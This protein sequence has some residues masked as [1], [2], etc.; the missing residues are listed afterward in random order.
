M[1]KAK[2][3][4]TIAFFLWVVTF[5]GW[6]ARA[7]T[8]D[9]R[10]GSEDLLAVSVFDHPELSVS[11]RVSK[12]G[13]IT[14]PLLGVLQVSGLTTRELEE[15]LSRRL[16]DGAYVQKAQVSVLVTDYESQK[17]AVMGQVAKPGQYAL[18][19]SNKVLDLL[20][21]AGGV[22]NGSGGGLAY[23]LAGDE[24][25]LVKKDGTKIKINL[26]ALFEGDPSQNPAVT[27]G[28]TIFV[29][30]APVF[31]IYGEV[32]KPGSYKLERN[33]TVYQ[34]ISEGGGL[35][36]KG[37]EHRL[38]VRRTGPDGKITELSVKGRDLLQ[39]DDVLTVK[40]SW[41]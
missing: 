40:E 17:V 5:T 33:M 24:A 6:S 39:P 21:Q 9:Y 23:A 37:S 29:P 8:N 20:A 31:Y 11:V 34:A 1:S 28:D 13:N 27:G 15:L 25:V 3:F 41:F 30:R 2:I 12:S 19:T 26:H 10:L 14:Y 4:A 16:A 32:Q 7:E 35:T 18:T 36:P 38:R 22:V